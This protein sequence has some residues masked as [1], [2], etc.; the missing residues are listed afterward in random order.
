[1]RK[2]CARWVRTV[3]QDGRRSLFQVERP[4]L[5]ESHQATPA[6][7]ASACDKAPF[8]P[9]SSM[10]LQMLK[11][12]CKG[13]RSRKSPIYT[14]R[15]SLLQAQRPPVRAA[16]SLLVGF[17]GLWAFKYHQSNKASPL[18]DSIIAVRKP[19]VQR[20]ALLSGLRVQPTSAPPS[21]PCEWPRPSRVLFARTVSHRPAGALFHEKGLRAGASS[22]RP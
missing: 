17:A 5:Q 3:S 18:A 6:Y 21:F 8:C 4:P 2:G 20:A 14:G 7:W 1:M 11:V 12:G 10:C 13:A 19:A 9:S 22:S 15:S 16:R